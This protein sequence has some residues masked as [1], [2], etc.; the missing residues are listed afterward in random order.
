[1][2]FNILKSIY[3]TERINL[4]TIISAGV[5]YIVIILVLFNYYDQKIKDAKLLFLNN[6]YNLI[7]ETGLNKFQSLAFRLNTNLQDTNISSNNNYITIC[8]NENCVNYSLYKLQSLLERSI[9]NFNNVR[10]ELNNNLIY[11]NAIFE[12][13]EMDKI[14]YLNQDNKLIIRTSINNDYWNKII[15]DIKKPLWFMITFLSLTF[16]AVYYI[17]QALSKKIEKEYKN[18][19]ETA[20]KECEKLWMTK[21]WDTEFK[22]TI[23]VEINYLF[24]QEAAKTTLLNEKDSLDKQD[25]KLKRSYLEKDLYC[26]IALYNSSNKEEIDVRKLIKVFTNRFDK[27]D[28]NISFSIKCLEKQI[29]FSS[30]AAFY[31]VIYSIINYL[32]F[33]IKKQFYNNKHQIN[34]FISNVAGKL[35]FSFSYSGV[36]LEKEK[37]LFAV[38]S[39]FTKSHANPFILSIEQIFKI[40]KSNGF[41]CKVSYDKTNLIEINEKAI[42]KNKIANE[43]NII[44]LA[45]W[46]KEE[47]D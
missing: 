35:S 42:K 32:F 44:Y 40:L 1:M 21:L 30:T 2:Y 24:N 19:Y 26:S 16:I 18:K 39:E 25:K 10:I 41:N 33:I 23:D 27:E 7:L 11:S 3:K 29:Y 46:D 17:Y 47:S 5:G 9:P 22:K 38:S 6:N 28:E 20:V 4:S 37:D 8:K 15:K 45:G 43:D 14:Y 31:Q 36:P 12:N 34:L 13:Y